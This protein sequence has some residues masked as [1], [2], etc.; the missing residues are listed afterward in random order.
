MG[1]AMQQTTGDQRP[2]DQLGT[3][4]MR[5]TGVLSALTACQDPERGTFAVGETFVLQAVAA[6]EGFISD[7]R[8]AYFELSADGVLEQR[9]PRLRQEQPLPAPPSPVTHQD[10]TSFPDDSLQEPA[11]PVQE[12]PSAL[13][14]DFYELRRRGA[15][16][17][18][19][20]TVPP[21][22]VEDGDF[23]HSY[24]AL[25]RKLTAAEVF[26]A[27]RSLGDDDMNSPLLP[28]LKSL[29]TDLERLRAA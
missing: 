9:K 10:F 8:N 2:I 15:A 16:A 17:A 27:E 29:R 21:P 22:A 12:E 13:L 3:A 25:L 18:P 7:A 19:N 28:L 14:P 26:A 24:D 6:L 5:A 4:L 23:V 11:Y 20:A 1:T